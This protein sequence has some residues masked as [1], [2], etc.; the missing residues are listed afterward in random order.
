MKYKILNNK[1]KE[2]F[3]FKNIKDI[4][5]FLDEYH[6]EILNGLDVSYDE[7]KYHQSCSINQILNE[8]KEWEIYKNERRVYIYER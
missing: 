4:K 2:G 7:L 1:T 8:Y 3:T 6:S 5:I